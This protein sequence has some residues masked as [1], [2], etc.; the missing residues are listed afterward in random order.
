MVLSLEDSGL[1]SRTVSKLIRDVRLR[2][3]MVGTR[4]LIPVTELQRWLDGESRGEVA[5]IAGHVWPSLIPVELATR[6]KN[7]GRSLARR[8]ISTNG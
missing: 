8:L 5:T 7:G 6:I 1:C 3:V 4:R 2:C